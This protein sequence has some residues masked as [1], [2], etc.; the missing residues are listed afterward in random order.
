MNWQHSYLVIA[1]DLGYVVRDVFA[2]WT[3]STRRL[4]RT[5]TEAKLAYL[6]RPDAIYQLHGDYLIARRNELKLYVANDQWRLAPNG[7]RALC[8][9]TNWW[10][11]WRDSFVLTTD[12]V[13]LTCFYGQ[14]ASTFLDGQQQYH[15]D[16]PSAALDCLADI[17][18]TLQ[19]GTALL[20]RCAHY[21]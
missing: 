1:L 7:R 11:E 18:R 5:T 10:L 21:V 2:V 14:V 17:V 12:L 3:Q 8:D 4:T 19:C 20:P 6:L 15:F 16:Y 13:V 9:R